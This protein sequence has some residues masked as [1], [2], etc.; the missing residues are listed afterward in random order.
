V[1]KVEAG[2]KIFRTDSALHLLSALREDGKGRERSS[3]A[4]NEIIDPE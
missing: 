1:I 4:R 3:A 2:R